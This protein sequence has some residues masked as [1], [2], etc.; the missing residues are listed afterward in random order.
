MGRNIKITNA[1]ENGMPEGIKLAEDDYE[2][3]Q[4]KEDFSHVKS[5]KVRQNDKMRKYEDE[6][7]RESIDNST[8]ESSMLA[9][10]L[11]TEAHKDKIVIQ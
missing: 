5:K 3:G 7:R 10:A 1:E 9:K 6:I 8:D 2:I 11:I 4:A